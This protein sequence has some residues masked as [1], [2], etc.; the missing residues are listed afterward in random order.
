M[1]KGIKINCVCFIQLSIKTFPFN[2]N[3]SFKFS[4]VFRVLVDRLRFILTQTIQMFYL[5]LLYFYFSY[6]PFQQPL[7]HTPLVLNIQR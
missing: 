7:S 5:R 3:Y 1:T 6:L 4:F 2:L